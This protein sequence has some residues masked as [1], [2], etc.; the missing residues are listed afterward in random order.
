MELPT[1]V[2]ARQIAIT[3][4]RSVGGYRYLEIFPWI[5]SGGVGV[6][7]PHCVLHENHR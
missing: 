1:M 3:P 6:P 7:H 4:D 2:Q 5:R